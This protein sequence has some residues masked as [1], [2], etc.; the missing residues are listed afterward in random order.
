MVLFLLALRNDVHHALGMLLRVRA[1]KRGVRIQSLV[2]VLRLNRKAV[3]QSRNTATPQLS[4]CI[5]NRK[6]YYTQYEI[7]IIPRKLRRAHHLSRHNHH[8]L[9]LWLP[10]SRATCFDV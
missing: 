1:M 5:N 10:I 2:V 7:L 6:N 8:L 9:H 3:T 4:S